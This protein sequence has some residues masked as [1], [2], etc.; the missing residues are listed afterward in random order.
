[1]SDGRLVDSFQ[2]DQYRE[3]NYD[4]NA[5][6]DFH[7]I[8]ETHF[9]TIADKLK[10]ADIRQL[11]D[12]QLQ[13]FPF[14]KDGVQYFAALYKNTKHSADFNLDMV[15]EERI[16]LRKDSISGDPIYQ[17][18]YGPYDGV[19][20]LDISGFLASPF[21]AQAALIKPFV[22]R[23]FEGAPHVRKIQVTG[24]IF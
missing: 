15:R 11:P 8:W 12:F 6:V 1:M 10:Q 19:L 14:E 18:K 17:H 2:Y 3:T 23:G 21:S 16:T 20:D 24:F 5:Q 7:T 9:P 4:E 22:R 13:H